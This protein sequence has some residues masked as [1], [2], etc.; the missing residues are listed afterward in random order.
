MQH[1]VNALF[2]R[3]GAVLLARRSPQRRSYPETWSF[4][5]GH[6][7]EGETLE[8]ALIREVQEEVGVT[9]MRFRALGTIQDPDPAKHG[10][11]TYHL[12]AVTAW[13]GGEPALLGDEHTELRWVGVDAAAHV[14]GL[15]IADYQH[16]FGQIGG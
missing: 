10:E 13:A 4:P 12:Y 1:I 16:F 2:V 3:D 5:G 9:P 8:E 6:V 11:V 14:E 15:A 7:E